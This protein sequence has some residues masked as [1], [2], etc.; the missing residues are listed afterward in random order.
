MVD[1]AWEGGYDGHT[2][3][4]V[5]VAIPG[6]FLPTPLLAFL[7]TPPSPHLTALHKNIRIALLNQ[8]KVYPV[9]HSV[10]NSSQPVLSRSLHL[11]YSVVYTQLL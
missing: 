9:E 10:S 4:L 3:V 7:I 5:I 6:T 11:A 8:A 2:P 1:Q